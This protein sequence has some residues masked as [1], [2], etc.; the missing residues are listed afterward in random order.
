MTALA[1][2]QNRYVFA[3]FSRDE[4]GIL[5]V[6]LHHKDGPMV[7]QEVVHREL[8]DLFLDIARD[9]DNRLVV[10]EGTGDTWCVDNDRPSFGG[11]ARGWDKVYWE[12]KSLLMNL[13]AIEVPVI[14]AVNGPARIHSEMPLLCDIVICSE[15]TLFQD[16]PHLAHDG[17]PPDMASVPG[18]GVQC[19]WPA[20]L[21]PNRGRYFLLM[22]HELSAREAL[23]L[24]VVSEVLPLDKL[25]DRAMEI[26]RELAARPTLALR[27]TRVALVQ[28]WK[29]LLL[30]KLGYGL[31][32]EGVAHPA[33]FKAG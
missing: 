25:H 24:G 16:A 4:Q 15:N 26:A 17:R 22:G 2:Y 8:P 21:G 12:G 11:F 14:V 32:L 33:Y 19:V 1:E 30:S 18:D 20:L 9:F 23:T 28:E 13:L 7:W 10:L 6:R 27:Y 3:K 31:A 5:Q 29:E